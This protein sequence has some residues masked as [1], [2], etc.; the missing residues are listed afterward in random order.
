MRLK[1]I[2]VVH[3]SHT[4]WGFTHDAPTVAYLHRRFLERAIP[5][6]RRHADRAPGERFTWSVET[7]AIMGECAT[8]GDPAFDVNELRALAQENLLE[9]LALASHQTPLVDRQ[10]LMASQHG[11][12]WIGPTRH[13]LSC[14]VNGQNWPLVDVLLE[15]GVTTYSSAINTHFGRAPGQRPELFMWEGPS[16]RAIP[17]FNGFHYGSANRFGIGKSSFHHLA[18]EWLPRLQAHLE[19]VGWRWPTL[20]LTAVHPFGDNGGPDETL[21]DWVHLWNRSGFDLKVELGTMEDWW[22][23]AEV[24]AHEGPRRR[25]DWTDFWNFGS[26][27]RAREMQIVRENRVRI[28]SAS[29]WSALIRRKLPTLAQAERANLLW[30]EHTFNADWA[31][32]GHHQDDPWTQGIHKSRLAADARTYSTLAQR[33]ALADIAARVPHEDGMLVFNPLPVP[34][35]ARGLVPAGVQYVRGYA[36]E[37]DPIAQRHTQDRNRDVELIFRPERQDPGWG[38]TP[39]HMLPPT[40]IPALSWVRVDTSVL[41]DPF[42]QKVETTDFNTA[43]NDYF[44]LTFDPKIGLIGW[45][46]KRTEDELIDPAS[47]FQFFRRYV[48]R[49]KDPEASQDPLFQMDWGS[50]EIEHPNGWPQP[51]PYRVDELAPITGLRKVTNR[52][53]NWIEFFCDESDG[54]RARYVIEMPHDAPWIEFRVEWQEGVDPRPRSTYVVFPFALGAHQ[55][56]V[57]VGGVSMRP[58]I[59]Q[60]PGVNHDYFT[61][62]DYV[63]LAGERSGVTISTAFNPLVMF[64]DF[65]FG[66]AATEFPGRPATFLGM[67]TNNY[68]QCNYDPVQPGRVVARYRIRPYSGAFNETEA[69]HFAAEASLRDPVLQRL[70][71]EKRPITDLPAEGTLLNVEGASVLHLTPTEIWLHNPTDA[72]TTAR[73]KP[74]LLPTTPVSLQ[75][76]PRQAVRLRHH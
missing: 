9:F 13:A 39:T 5:M 73:V 75:I 24:W 27:S 20:M 45:F 28:R 33:E 60:L 15:S 44:R 41:V 51:R 21:P 66:D 7:Q 57:D 49:P 2:L 64:G 1:K 68:W 35:T 53:G 71:E 16:G 32:D 48:E 59:D 52:L 3:H 37:S 18:E 11:Q 47:P 62:Q 46:D 72:P 6:M 76:G 43:E 42:D 34:I 22:R 40:L 56:R 55:P 30:S 25:G 67:I 23:E 61:A 65:H 54:T 17:A 4:D 10:E 69:R 29:A 26:C 14:D 38:Q 36:H 8:Q 74:G 70:D 19:R 31:R 50:W 58:G 63:D 12:S